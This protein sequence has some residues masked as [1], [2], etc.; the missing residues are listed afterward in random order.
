MINM[1]AEKVTGEDFLAIRSSNPT[2]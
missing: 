1:T 2:S